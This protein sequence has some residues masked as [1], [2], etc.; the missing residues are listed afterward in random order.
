V[1]EA[2]KR[3]DQELEK[4]GAGEGRVNYRLRDAAFGRQRYW[5]EPI[6][7]YYKDGVPYPL[8]E[9]E[10]PLKLPEIDKYQP[11]ETGEPPLARAAN[12]T[13]QGHPLETTTMPGWAGSSWYFLRYMDPKNEGRFASADA[14]KYWQAGGSLRGRQR[15]RDRHLIYFRFWTKFLFDRGWIP[16]EEPAKKLVNQ[17]MIQGVSTG[18]PGSLYVKRAKRHAREYF[19]SQCQNRKRFMWPR[20]IRCTET[21]HPESESIRSTFSGNF[22]WITPAHCE[23]RFS[24]F[25]LMRTGH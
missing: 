8:P 5:G 9:S 20:R 15:A 4:I 19:V 25:L 11:T 24:G 14:I 2:I 23:K 17:G 12:W 16:F 13:Y 18:H 1:P 10:L 7:I 22:E 3:R 6:P 21:G